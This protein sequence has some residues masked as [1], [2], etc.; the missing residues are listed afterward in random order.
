[1]SSNREKVNESAIEAKWRQE[2]ND[3]STKVYS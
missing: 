3:E 1:M 2:K